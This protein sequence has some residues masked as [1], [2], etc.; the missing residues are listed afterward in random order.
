MKW[1]WIKSSCEEAPTFPIFF[2]K[3]PTSFILRK[4]SKKYQSFTT[5]SKFLKNMKLWCQGSFALLW[6]FSCLFCIM[7]KGSEEFS[8]RMFWQTDYFHT[9]MLSK[10]LPL[11][12]TMLR[13][14]HVSS[15]A[16]LWSVEP[17][18]AQNPEN[19]KSNYFCSDKTGV[20]SE[21][22]LLYV[23]NSKVNITISGKGGYPT[24]P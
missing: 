5:F 19:R 22:A 1:F 10:T 4:Y 7:L 11:L 17:P 13:W 24:P 21:N 3:N 20:F 9:L 16:P 8:Q 12:V 14:R 23:F 2:L 15:H 18:R 6:C